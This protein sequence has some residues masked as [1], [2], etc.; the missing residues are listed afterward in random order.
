[1]PE[2]EDVH[3]H[4]QRAL[5]SLLLEDHAGATTYLRSALTCLTTANTVKL[6][7]SQYNSFRADWT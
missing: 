6:K 7:K 5:Q 3:V 4:V 1:M 2:P